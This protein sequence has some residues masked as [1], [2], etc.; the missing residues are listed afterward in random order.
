MLA[1][2]LAFAQLQNE[3]RFQTSVADESRASVHFIQL[4]AIRAL[5]HIMLTC[6]CC[7]CCKLMQEQGEEEVW[8]EIYC[9]ES[10][11]SL[12]SLV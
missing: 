8:V 2:P 7:C 1:D 5:P 10:Y 6:C 4:R 11:R 12:Q 3:T 9:L